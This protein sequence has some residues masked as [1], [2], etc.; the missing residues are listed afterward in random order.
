MQS[1]QPILL[2]SCARAASAEE[3]RYRIDGPEPEA[4]AARVI[5]LDPGAEEVLEGLQGHPWRSAHFLAYRPGNPVITGNGG[6]PDVTLE[7]LR[8][9]GALRLSEELEGADMVVMVATASIG[10]DAAAAIGEACYR[11][12]IMTGGVVFGDEIDIGEAVLALRPQAQ[13]LLVT[14][15]HDDLPEILTALRA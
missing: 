2:N 9:A 11:R 7:P 6:L 3:L 8:G 13:V 10:A 15:D 12:G 4:R 14:Q 1:R 5:A